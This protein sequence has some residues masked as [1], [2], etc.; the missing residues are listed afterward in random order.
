MKVYTTRDGEAAARRLAADFEHV[1]VRRDVYARPNVPFRTSRLSDLK[2]YWDFT[3]QQKANWD[4]NGG[5]LFTRDIRYNWKGLPCDASLHVD[6]PPHVRHF[7]NHTA[8]V[9]HTSAM[10]LP[11]NWDAH[12]RACWLRFPPADYV[13]PAFKAIMA[14][15]TPDDPTR[16]AAAQMFGIDW[17]AARVMT[18]DEFAAVGADGDKRRDTVGMREALYRAKTIPEVYVAIP[19]IRPMDDAQQQAAFDWLMTLPADGDGRVVF[20]IRRLIEVTNGASTA[21]YRMERNGNII[22]FPFFYVFD[23]ESVDPD[24]GAI[25]SK[26]ERQ[27]LLLEQMIRYVESLPTLPL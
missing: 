17:P 18:G 24:F 6:V 9:R 22:R 11:V 1:V 19:R 16:R 4:A 20:T 27:A 26:H 8:F 14:W 10:V 5:I 25:D 7:V 15:E 13:R 2:C 21:L 3:E 23:V 12:R